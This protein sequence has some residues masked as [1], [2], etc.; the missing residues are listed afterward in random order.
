[1]SDVV[2]PSIVDNNSDLV[3][4]VHFHSLRALTVRGSLIDKEG[5]SSVVGAARG[6][7]QGVYLNELNPVQVEMFFGEL[8][9]LHPNG[10]SFSLNSRL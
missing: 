4:Y 9:L 8:H 7:F 6:S 2:L 5:R 10:S 3:D 1:M